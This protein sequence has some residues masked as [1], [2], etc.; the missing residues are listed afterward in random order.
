MISYIKYVFRLRIFENRTVRRIFGA[1]WDEKGSEYGFTVR[2]L[3][4]F[5]IH[6]T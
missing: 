5:T 3:I 4:M 2:V 6:L 1:K